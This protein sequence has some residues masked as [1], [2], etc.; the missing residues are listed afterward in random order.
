MKSL[1]LT[2]VLALS[3]TTTVA[4]AVPYTVDFTSLSNG[5]AAGRYDQLSFKGLTVSARTNV[6][7]SN[8]NIA[9]PWGPHP[10]ARNGVPGDVYWG[11]LGDLG[12]TG[13][14]Y[15]GLGVL[16]NDQTPAN[17]S[18]GPITYSETLLFHFATNQVGQ[19]MAQGVGQQL[20]FNML[21][22]QAN[23][24][25]NAAAPADNMRVW[26]KVASGE[27]AFVDINA[28]AVALFGPDF[29]LAIDY[30]LR[31]SNFAN[32]LVTDFGVE[33]IYGSLANPNR[34]FGFAKLTYDAPVPEPGTLFLLGA[35][36]A[37]LA[38]W[39]KKKKS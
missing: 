13:Q 5:Y 21:G 23:A 27:V 38:L 18:T 2:L 30:A 28:G 6:G 16:T 7:T 26:I 24:K 12:V 9:N 17:S 20:H 8:G 35:G 36:L 31:F 10:P 29:G 32:E 25:G 15:F 39:R 34:Q 37:S 3:L 22:L 33:E 19:G 14:S 4:F 1:M 11:A